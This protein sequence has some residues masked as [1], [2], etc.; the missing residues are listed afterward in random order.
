V[1]HA[2]TVASD[3]PQ[4][5]IFFNVTRKPSQQKE[6]LMPVITPNLWFDTEAL[7]AA[8]FYVSV[9]PNSK[10][11]NVFYYTASMGRREPGSVLTVDFDLDG[12]RHT[13]INGGPE[14]MFSE[15]VSLLVNCTGQA[16]VDHYWYALSQGG[17]ESMCG[18]LKDRY[19]FS[20]QIFPTE[21]E[22]LMTDADPERVDRAMAALMTM[23]KIDIAL[24]QQAAKEAAD[25]AG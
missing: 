7:E 19:G 13:A 12:Q 2:D 15:A 9:F 24:L 23:K 6:A 22:L 25:H 1:W 5:S 14:F 17:E 16:E 10:I 21:L 18:W 4:P 20:W 3:S 8:E 11:T